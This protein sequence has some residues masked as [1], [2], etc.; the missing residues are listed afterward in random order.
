MEVEY[1]EMQDLIS[2]GETL[3][4][5][6]RG[7]VDVLELEGHNILEKYKETIEYD[8]YVGGIVKQIAH[9]FPQMNILEIG[10]SSSPPP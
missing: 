9:L 4:P 6:V 10:R 3:I 2:V 5:F 7:Q 1:S 8:A